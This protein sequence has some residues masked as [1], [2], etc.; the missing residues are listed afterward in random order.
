VV[1]EAVAGEGCAVVGP[2]LVGAPVVGT[3][4]GLSSPWS[5]PPPFMSAYTEP[6]AP[7]ATTRATTTSSAVERPFLRDASGGAVTGPA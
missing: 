7:S 6:P 5:L 2:G 4:L 1:G 3:G